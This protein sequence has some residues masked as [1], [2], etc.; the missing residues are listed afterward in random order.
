MNY[1]VFLSHNGKDKPAVEQIGH[2]LSQKYGLTCWLDKWNLV[3]GEPWQEALEEA[4]DQC[5]TVAVFVGPNMIGPW[6]NEEMRAA[7]ETR[8]HGKTRRVIP[9]LLPGALDSKDL[10]LPRFLSRLTWVDFRNGL[11]DKNALYRLYCGIQGIKPGADKG[12]AAGQ[13]K[14]LPLSP[15]LTTFFLR[16]QRNRYAWMAIVSVA[17]L[18]L[19]MLWTS[20]NIDMPIFCGKTYTSAPGYINLATE[21]RNQGRL[22]C[23]IH[24]L[25]KALNVNP[26]PTEKAYIYYKLASIYVAKLEGGDPVNALKFADDGLEVDTAYQDLLHASKGI[27]YCEMKQNV[28]ALEEFRIFLDLTPSPSSAL[29]N[30]VKD[31]LG[32]LEAGEDMGDYC[33]NDLGAQSLP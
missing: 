3:P 27:A 26:T 17:I 4:L 15:K 33:W 16:F 8:V 21:Q 31:V 25:Q 10:K 28:R 19:L 29:A 30:R 23:A 1:D 9:V 13:A 24:N 11:D 22:A 7:L 18:I 14:G 5:R 32:D 6:E 12:L 2:M 20:G